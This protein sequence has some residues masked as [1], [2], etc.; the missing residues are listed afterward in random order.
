MG[1]GYNGPACTPANRQWYLLNLPAAVIYH[2]NPVGASLAHA[3]GLNIDLCL[4]QETV[5]EHYS[6]PYSQMEVFFL[7]FFRRVSKVACPVLLS[8]PHNALT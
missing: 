4:I 2:G 7:I 3:M 6:L 1:V 8:T 5:R